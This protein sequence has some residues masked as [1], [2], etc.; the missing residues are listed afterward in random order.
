MLAF[1]VLPKLL[2]SLL[3]EL[4]A[5]LPAGVGRLAI[6]DCF[7]AF[8]QSILVPLVAL[9]GLPDG[10]ADVAEFGFA[11]AAFIDVSTYFSDTG[12]AWLT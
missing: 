12:P 10:A 11:D 9:A 6:H 3:D 5:V 2:G 4:S 7:G 8:E 1:V